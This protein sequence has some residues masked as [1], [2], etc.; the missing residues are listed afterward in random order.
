MAGE[1]AQIQRCQIHKT[2]NVAEHL[3]EEHQSAIRCKLRDAHAMREYVDAKRA[4]ETLLHQLMHLNPSAA[5]SLEECMEET[6]TVHRLRVPNKLRTQL[7]SSNLIESAF[8]T[9]DTVCRNVK[10]WQGSDQRLRWVASGL[11]WAESRWNKL[12][13]AAEIPVLMKEMEL[14][15][16]KKMPLRHAKAA[17]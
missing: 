17:S 15:V 1:C 5:R 13:H 4:L 14:A 2:L 7:A 11:L 8:A 12:H 9:V 6:L 3:T 16:V 10:R